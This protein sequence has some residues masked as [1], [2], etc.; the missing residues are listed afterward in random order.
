MTLHS[1]SWCPCQ[2]QNMTLNYKIDTKMDL[3]SRNRILSNINAQIVYE[4]LIT[5]I[6][7]FFQKNNFSKAIVTSSGG[8]DSALVLVLACHALGSENVLALLLPSRYS[9]E[10]SVIDAQQ[11]SERLNNPFKII[12]IDNIFQSTLDTLAPDFENLP[13]N[14]AEENIQSRI[15]GM[16]AMA[17]S[18]K[19]GSIL[20]N[21]TNKSERSLGYGTLYG[22]MAGAISVIGDL[23]KTHVYALANFI[24]ETQ[25][26]IPINIIQ[27]AP[28]AE[29][30][31]NQLDSDSLPDYKLL[32]NIL[33]A[34]LDV[35]MKKEKISDL[36]FSEKMV[37]K[38]INQYHKSSFKREQSC[39]IIQISSV[40]NNNYNKRP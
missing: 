14:V 5:G 6:K 25:E 28:S 22:D 37:E 4:E 10:S 13:F 31:P 9:S 29:L 8:I 19:F 16:L 18:N 38:I 1:S 27:K 12:S 39:P 2:L 35:K 7:T 20:L 40:Y 3:K 26:I 36:G 33:C 30:R 34:Y 24:N 15:R 11:L 17:Y 21:C 32:D 23:Y